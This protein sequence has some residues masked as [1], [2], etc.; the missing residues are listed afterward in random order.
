M[1]KQ[2]DKDN[3]ISNS[4]TGTVDWSVYLQQGVIIDLQIKRYRGTTTIG[5]PELGINPDTSAEYSNFLNDYLKP[6]QKRLTPPEIESS[7]KSIETQA[8]NNLKECSYD[9][10]AFDSTGKFVPAT[11][12]QA[13]KE[14][15]KEFERRFWDIRDEFANSYDDIIERVRKDYRLLAIN[16]YKQSHPDADKVPTRFINSFV[17]GIIEQIP[18]REEIVASF[19]YNTYLRR[20]PPYLLNVIKKKNDIDEKAMKIA[21]TR[22]A[23]KSASN[24]E[25]TASKENVQGQEASS[26][27]SFS[28]DP[29]LNQEIEADLM[30]SIEAESNAVFSGFI[31]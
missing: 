30:D 4:S 13:F 17:N 3:K 19:E 28:Q 16:L 8:R 14:Q 18:P 15:N 21:A 12:Y 1:S 2:N 6:G 5:F 9:C 7:L 29:N 27:V 11:A 25:V 24:G 20:I 10:S 22:R 26:V 23:Q 31:H